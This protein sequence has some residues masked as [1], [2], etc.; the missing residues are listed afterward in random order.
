MGLA[1][2]EISPSANQ[3]SL[4]WNRSRRVTEGEGS[5]YILWC[6]PVL[7]YKRCGWHVFMSIGKA[8]FISAVSYTICM[9]TFFSISSPL[10]SNAQPR[11]GMLTRALNQWTW[12]SVSFSSISFWNYFDRFFLACSA[13][14]CSASTPRPSPTAWVW[15]VLRWQ[16]F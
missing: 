1:L 4:R 5:L 11:E 10:G 2:G 8:L 3:A 6:Y 13:L 9:H 12:W 7:T 14:L 16:T 15:H